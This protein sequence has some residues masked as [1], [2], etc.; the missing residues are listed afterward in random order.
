MPFMIPDWLDRQARENKRGWYCPSCGKTTVYSESEVQKLRR[1]L[2]AERSRTLWEQDQ[3]A[4]TE[5]SLAATK[6][7]IT[8]IKKRVGKGVCP[9]CNRHFANVE[10]HMETQH[11]DYAEGAT[12]D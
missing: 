6:G 3:R 1:Q 2:D 5:R 9:C 10:R 12:N 4:A 8:K 7:Q 11:P